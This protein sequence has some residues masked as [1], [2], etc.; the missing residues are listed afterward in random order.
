[1]LEEWGT[2][3]IFFFFKRNVNNTDNELAKNARA[4]KSIAHFGNQRKL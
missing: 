3:N 1:M 2:E 4:L